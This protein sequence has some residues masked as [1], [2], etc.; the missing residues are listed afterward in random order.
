[1]GTD[2]RAQAAAG[3][4]CAAA[5]WA[6]GAAAG[7][8]AGAAAGVSAAAAA[9]GGAL[10]G[11]AAAVL[12]A[13]AAGAGGGAGIEAAMFSGALLALPGC[14]VGLPV[15]TVYRGMSASFACMLLGF[16]H[17]RVCVF[18]VSLL[19]LFECERSCISEVCM[20]SSFRTIVCRTIVCEGTWNNATCICSHVFVA[21]ELYSARRATAL[22]PLAPD[23]CTTM[24]PAEAPNAVYTSTT[25][26]LD[27]RRWCTSAGGRRG[28][29]AA[30]QLLRRDKAQLRRLRLQVRAAAPPLVRQP[31]AV[32]VQ[33]VDAA[34]RA[35]RAVQLGPQA[36]QRAQCMACAQVQAVDTAQR[37]RQWR[38]CQVRD[39][40][41]PY[42]CWG[43]RPGVC[44]AGYGSERA[45][46]LRP[47]QQLSGWGRALQDH[48]R[49]GCFTAR[50]V[51]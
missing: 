31:E 33:V 47:E 27:A 5:G 36:G 17:R 44:A 9:G 37:R 11:A 2:R 48:A 35:R 24:F 15:Y 3:G 4:A 42:R 13:A 39:Q 16:I 49:P 25:S 29:Q 38:A 34:R 7:W 32:Q 12:A 18:T 40:A 26:G 14:S 45:A 19:R 8:A 28:A 21:Q 22:C 6:A 51:G 10:A 1:M 43:G 30:Q 46:R 23:A 50:R 41:P 20:H